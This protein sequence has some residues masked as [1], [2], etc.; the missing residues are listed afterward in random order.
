MTKQVNSESFLFKYFLSCCA[1]TIS[2]SGKIVIIC[3]QR[4]MLCVVCRMKG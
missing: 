4:L 3:M 2:E 1:A